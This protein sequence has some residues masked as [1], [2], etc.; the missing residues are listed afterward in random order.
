MKPKLG[1]VVPPDNGVVEAELQAALVPRCVVHAAR[2]PPLRSLSLLDRLDAYRLRMEEPV[3]SLSGLGL[4]ALLTAC[5][6]A[7][8]LAGPEADDATDAELAGL[9]GCPLRSVAGAIRDA[10]GKRGTERLH[11]VSPYPRDLTER[12]VAFFERAGFSVVGLSVVDGERHPY[13]I[14]PAEL[15]AVLAEID[16]KG[17]SAEVVLLTGT[18]VATLGLVRSASPGRVEVLSSISCGLEWLEQV[19]GERT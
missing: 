3:G 4:D 2:L 16:A 12:S 6:G 18:G 11:L 19:L 7:S 13:D 9:A 8:Y 17:T 15:A 14:G 1:V 10:L 5:T